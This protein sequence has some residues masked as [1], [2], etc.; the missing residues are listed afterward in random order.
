MSK[1]GITLNLQNVSGNAFAILG[2]ARRA[3]ERAG[4]RELWDEF[5][6]EA[7]SGDYNNLLCTVSDWFDVTFGE[8]EDE[9]EYDE[10]N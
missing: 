8:D 10:E 4:K 9:E 2:V 1:T 3:M 5:H 6:K 7:T